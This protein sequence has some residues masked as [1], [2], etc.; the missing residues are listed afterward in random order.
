MEFNSGIHTIPRVGTII[1]TVG[2]IILTVGFFL[3]DDGW[4]TRLFLLNDHAAEK[5]AWL[6]F[7]SVYVYF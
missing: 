1:P 4:K 2:T 3:F 5:K 7:L 6:K